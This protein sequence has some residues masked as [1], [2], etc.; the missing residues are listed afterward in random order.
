MSAL[1][2]PR[3]AAFVAFSS[4]ALESVLLRPST[5]ARSG[6]VLVCGFGSL[7]AAGRCAAR[8]ARRSGVAVAIRPGP[9]GAAGEWQV[10][11]PVAVR[12]SRWPVGAGRLLPVVGGLRGLV[13]ALGRAGVVRGC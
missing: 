9:G 6:A 3:S 10:S 1:F 12:S 7:P 11:A 4:G 13:A 5:H 8:V 2:S